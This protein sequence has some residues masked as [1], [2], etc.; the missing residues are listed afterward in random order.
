MGAR[1]LLVTLCLTSCGRFDFAPTTSP[2]GASDVAT[3]D[4]TV[5]L[6][7]RFPLDDVPSSGHLQ[8]IPASRT[9][10]CGLLCPAPSVTHVVGAGGVYFGGNLRIVL[11]DLIPAGP[12]T[13]TVWLAPA[14]SLTFGSA[15]GKPLDTTTVLNE[16][17]LT[18]GET[19][20]FEGARGGAVVGADGPVDIRGSVHHVALVFDGTSRTVVVDGSA[21]VPFPGPFETSTLP[22]AIGAD[23]DANAFA[24]PYTGM[25]DDLRF[26]SRALRLDEIEAI[27]AER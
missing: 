9:V 25:M 21:K 3:P 10:D 15:L 2:D 13:I 26:Y 19:V 17:S 12:Y 23:L 8:A 24:F 7:A 18:I 22:V 27:R 4:G 16:V 11:G 14:A 5:D 1:C 20:G 6:I